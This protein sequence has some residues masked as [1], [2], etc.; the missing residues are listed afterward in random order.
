MPFLQHISG[1]PGCAIIGVF[2]KCAI[3]NNILFVDGRHKYP[4]MSISDA[5]LRHQANGAFMIDA[6][7]IYMARAHPDAPPPRSFSATDVDAHFRA[8]PEILRVLVV[9]AVS[10][11]PHRD[12]EEIN[13]T[14]VPDVARNGGILRG[15]FTRGCN[16]R[17]LRTMANVY[18]PIGLYMLMKIYPDMENLMYPFYG[19]S[20]LEIF[21]YDSVTIRLN[22]FS[23]ELTELS[24]RSE[25]NQGIMMDHIIARMREDNSID[26]RFEVDREDDEN[27]ISSLRV[28]SVAELRRQLQRFVQ[29]GLDVITSTTN[30]SLQ[31]SLSFNVPFGAQRDDDDILEYLDRRVIYTAGVTTVDR[32][33]YT[34]AIVYTTSR[35]PVR[36]MYYGCIDNKVKLEIKTMPN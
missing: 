14:P 34:A 15:P 30:N 31:M 6:R 7:K 35:T 24:I 20:Y 13:L 17:A 5:A 27:N 9:N 1:S 11:N 29:A 4:N 28:D 33:S 10:P 12:L 22:M 21:T 3:S 26:Y 25:Q 36:K 32:P 16:G 2:T 18:K 8:I 23:D 19:K